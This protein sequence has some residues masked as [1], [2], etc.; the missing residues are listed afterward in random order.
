MG[1]LQ[2]PNQQ[3]LFKEARKLKCI[4]IQ[5]GVDGVTRGE[6][7]VKPDRNRDSWWN[8]AKRR[9]EMSGS[10]SSPPLACV[11]VARTTIGTLLSISCAQFT[12]YAA[13]D[14][15]KPEKARK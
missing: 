12:L 10:S 14:N 11:A 2:L 4:I 3:A 7:K 9:A 15:E 6:S 5:F 8:A 1:A 13:F